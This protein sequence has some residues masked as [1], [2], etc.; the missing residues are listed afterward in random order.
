MIVFTDE[1]MSVSSMFSFSKSLL[2]SFFV[3]VV[4]PRFDIYVVCLTAESLTAECLIAS[5]RISTEL[6]SVASGGVINITL[7]LGLLGGVHRSFGGSSGCLQTRDPIGNRK[8][9]Y[10][11]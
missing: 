9:L 2:L 11:A 4:S 7:L 1:A 3:Y 8:H 6:G 10:G 5:S